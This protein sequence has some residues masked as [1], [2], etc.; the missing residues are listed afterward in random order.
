[1]VPTPPPPHP[2]LPSVRQGAVCLVVKMA[3]E[4]PHS[5]LERGS[6]N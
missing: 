2:G 1:M 4:K 3:L 6:Y 5:S